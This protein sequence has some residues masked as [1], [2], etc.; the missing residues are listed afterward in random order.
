[1]LTG[2][3][4]LLLIAAAILFIVVMG[5]TFK[6]NPFVVLL[7]AALLTGIFSGIPL[8]ILPMRRTKALAT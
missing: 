8:V 6:I 4:L 1:M 5:S 2:I 3:P 7:L